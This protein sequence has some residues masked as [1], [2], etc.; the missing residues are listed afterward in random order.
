MGKKTKSRHQQKAI[1]D[2]IKEM[3]IRIASSQRAVEQNE[4]EKTPSL[5]A[6]IIRY[7]TSKA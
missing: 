4:K 5:F 7:P 1:S 6:K 2:F 3:D